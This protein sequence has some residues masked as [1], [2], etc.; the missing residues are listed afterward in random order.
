MAFSSCCPGDLPRMQL[1]QSYTMVNE[2]GNDLD[3]LK[4][5][6][7]QAAGYGG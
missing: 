6:R 1:H 3:I 4:I 5:K 7:L 2:F